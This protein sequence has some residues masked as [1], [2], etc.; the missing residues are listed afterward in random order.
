MKQSNTHKSLAALAAF[1]PRIILVGL[2]AYLGTSA[3]LPWL[4]PDHSGHELHAQAVYTDLTDPAMIQ[5]FHEVSDGLICQCGCHF[6]LSSCPHVECPWGIPV[7]RFI[8]IKILE[9]MGAEEI[10]AKME[11][12]FGPDIRKYELV[13]GFLAAG[14][15]DIVEGLENGWGPGVSAHASPFGLIGIVVFAGL[16]AIFLFLYWWRRNRKAAA[17]ADDAQQPPAAPPTPEGDTDW[18]ARVRDLDR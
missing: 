8:E 1:A 16:T 12:G 9:G 11:T 13:Q 10:L 18:E 15:E 17:F 2:L 3:I 5:V 14:R 7:R 6:V 4:Q